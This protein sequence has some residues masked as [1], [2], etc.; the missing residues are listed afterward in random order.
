MKYNKEDNNSFAIGMF[1]TMELLNNKPQNV[2]EIYYHKNIKQTEDVVKL[3]KLCEQK[4]I[5]I[6]EKTKFIENLAKKEN[7]FIVAEFKKFYNNID[8][9]NHLV[10]VNPSD[11]GN[12][13][14][15]LRTALAND[16]LNIAIIK[17]CADIFNP[18]VVRASMGAIF[19]LNIQLFDS[20]DDYYNQFKNRQLYMFCLQTNTYL[21]DIKSFIAPYSLVFGN[22]ATGLPQYI[23]DKGQKVKI[24][25]SK[26]VDSFNLA[27][28]VAMALYHSTLN[29]K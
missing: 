25:Q 4:H 15:I 13:G 17:P 10:L 23:C 1:A 29:I 2:I 19:S 11:M 9:K 5:K 14:T 22:E 8:N 24:K 28:S 7:V 20:F 21:Q 18:K 16:F 27:I 3:F 26:K 12:L 6:T